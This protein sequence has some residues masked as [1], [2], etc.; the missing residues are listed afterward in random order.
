MEDIVDIDKERENLRRD[1]MSP[2]GTDK[3]G[4]EDKNYD[5]WE[6]SRMNSEK[7]TE[8]KT[9]HTTQPQFIPDPL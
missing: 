7:F 1:A 9:L 2:S 5:R 6:A 3:T 4:Y 8:E